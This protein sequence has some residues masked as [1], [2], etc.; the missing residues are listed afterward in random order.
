MNRHNQDEQEIEVD[1]R[2]SPDPNRDWLWATMHSIGDAVIATD[3]EGTVTFMNPVAESL[4]GW[5]AQEAEGLPLE[6]VFHIVD[7]VTGRPVESPVQETLREGLIVGL[8][9]H[10]ILIG[11]DGTRRAIDD[12][13]APIQGPDGQ[14]SGVV[15]VFR[16]VSQKRIAERRRNARLAVTQI[17]ATETSARKAIPDV[18][19]AICL[20]LE[21]DFASFWRLV[22]EDNALRCQ[23]SWVQAP[24]NFEAFCEATRK[25]TF[26]PGDSLPGQAWKRGQPIWV[27]DVVTYPGFWRASE[28]REVGLHGGFACPVTAGPAFLGVIECF[29]REI[30]EPDEDLLEMM[31]TISGQIGQFLERRHAEEKLRQSEEMLADFFEN[32]TVGLQCVG[33]DGTV[34]RANQAALDLLGYSREEYIGRNFAEVHIDRNLAEQMLRRLHAGERLQ[35]VEARLRRNDGALRDVLIDSSVLW[36]GDRFIHSRCFLRDI[37]ERKQ[38]ENA[39]R[40]SEARFRTFADA[41]PV[42]IW[43]SGPQNEGVYFNQGWL[44]FTGQTVEQQ[45]G[46]GWFELVHPDDRKSLSEIRTK[47]F[48]NRTS[49]TVEFRMKRADGEYRWLLD[50]GTPRFD[51][52]GNFAGFIGSCVD[53]TERKQAEETQALLAAVVKSSD[54]AVISKTIDGTITSWN[55]AAERIY[56]YTAAEAIGQPITIIVPPELHDEERGFLEQLHR[57]EQIAHF[58]TVRLSK[59]GRRIDV[60]LTISPVRDSKGQII[61]ASKLARDITDRRR[62]E[63][64]LRESEERFRALG[65]NIPQLAWM[66]RPDG[67]IFWYNRR[68]FEYTGTTLEE[69]QGWGWLKVHHPDHV[70]SV[71]Q[72]YNKAFQA[73]EPWEDTFPLRGKDGSYC[74]FLSRAF[75]IRDTSGKITCWFGTNT[76]I[77][78]LLTTQAALRESERRLST[79]VANLPGTA[80]RCG[81]DRN[82]VMEFVSQG[83]A[84]MTGHSPDDFTSRRVLWSELIHPDDEGFVWETVQRAVRERRP[85]EMEYRIRHR[86]GSLRWVWE[87][88]EG[89]FEEGPEPVALEG[90]ITDIT[91]RKHAEEALRRSQERL[92]IALEAS[93]AAAWGWN[94]RGNQVDEWSP[95]YREL[96]GFGPNEPASLQTWLNQIHPADRIRLKLRV[97]QIRRTPG[98]DVWNEEFRICHPEHGMRWI[99]GIGRCT[100]NESGQLLRMTGVNLDITQ[101]KQFEQSLKFLADVSE[102]LALLV[103]YK[104]TLNKVAQLA[105]PDFADWCAVDLADGTGS[106]YRVAV[107][108][109]DPAKVRLAEELMRRYPP[110]PNAGHGIMK[111]LRTGESDMAHTITDELLNI[112]AQDEEHRSILKELNPTSY[113]CLPLKTKDNTFGVVTFVSAESGRHYGPEDLSLA[114]EIARRAAIA[115]ENAR[116]Y[117]EVQ[118]ADRRKDEFLAMLAHELR[119]PLAPIRSGLDI[120]AMDPQSDRD[121]IGIMQEQ[122]EHVVRLVDDLLDVSRI[123]RGKIELRKKPVQLSLLIKHSVE[124]IRPLV[125]S[126]EQELCVFV[127]DEPIWLYADPVRLLQVFENLLTNSAKYTEAGGRIEI[128]A[129]IQGQ[130]TVVTVKDTGVGIE[131][132]LLPKVFEL[133]IQSSRSLDRAKGG[134]GIGLTLVRRLVELHEGTVTAHSDGPGTG[135]TFVVRL[136]LTE[137]PGEAKVDTQPEIIPQNLRILVVDDNVGAAVLLSKLLA[138][139]GDHEIETAHDGPSALAKIEEFHPDIV[140]LDIGLPGMDGFQVAETIRQSPEFDDVL[141]VALTGYGQKED[142]QKSKEVG[143]DE[144]QVKPPS[145]DQLKAILAHPKLKTGQREPAATAPKPARSASGK[146]E[147]RGDDVQPPASLEKELREIKHDLGNVAYVLSLIAEMF[148]NSAIDGDANTRAREAMQQEIGTINRLVQ[149][150]QSLIEQRQA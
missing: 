53:I 77:T 71:S 63:E 67:W 48:I 16:D 58:E 114:E 47:G 116:L 69:M 108:H 82:W 28:A 7:E 146:R 38:A 61:G 10:T 51:P 80:F 54:D 144:H 41:A 118:D 122:V 64:A 141:L 52:D 131:P 79:L 119:N 87:H 88:G 72:K 43:V 111:A 13:A 36:E 105:V 115:I 92:A 40:E 83:V 124:A 70:E 148:M 81:N 75:P 44:S 8:A 85:F 130:E 109:I 46:Q 96:Y 42:M 37:T 34:L 4:T 65:E 22:P 50:T 149:S 60:S 35:N 39:L 89:I 27:E 98:D 78:E 139:L 90:F 20:A 143:F 128:S 138:K 107:A 140:L 76:D 104:S 129:E 94:V 117:Q 84:A 147:R 6:K 3:A 133:F 101:R 62:A 123:M 33:P 23:D 150:L 127:P 86:D 45:Q 11:R 136:P 32:A 25:L 134:L 1:A 142:R 66:T 21:W 2:R 137:L 29:S 31:K 74:W 49:F 57:G 73:G 95:Q 9:N 68:W 145:L 24:R 97:R 121:V 12:S 15:L 14:I 120:L 112:A 55:A 100:R 91:V 30:Q 18:L 125:E 132:E 135:S 103:D 19:A 17:L 126:H 99:A 56:G 5:D 113:M 106:I 110:D 59:Q 102:S 26:Q 93:G